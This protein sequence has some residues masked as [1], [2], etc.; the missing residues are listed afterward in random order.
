[1]DGGRA[2]VDG[3]ITLLEVLLDESLFIILVDERLTICDEGSHDEDKELIE[4][5]EVESE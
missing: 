1:M 4:V 2:A 3:L 5:G